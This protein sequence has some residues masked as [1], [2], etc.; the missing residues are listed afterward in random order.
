MGLNFRGVLKDEIRTVAI[1]E[2]GSSL[3]VCLTIF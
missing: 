2:I 3:T 1:G